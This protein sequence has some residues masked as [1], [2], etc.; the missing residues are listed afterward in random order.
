MFVQSPLTVKVPLAG[1]IVPIPTLPL[2]LTNKKEVEPLTNW[3]E[4]ELLF[5]LAVIDPV[6]IWERLRPT[7]AEAGT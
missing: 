5:T 4:A 7:T 3:K 6:A 1:V 2:L